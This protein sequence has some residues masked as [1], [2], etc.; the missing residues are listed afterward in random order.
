[1]QRHCC[2]ERYRLAE[3]SQPVNSGV[4]LEGLWLR[5]PV[6]LDLIIITAVALHD[7]YFVSTRAESTFQAET[8]SFRTNARS[9]RSD[10]DLLSDSASNFH[11]AL[12]SQAEST[13][14]EYH[15]AN[16]TDM[17]LH[18]DALGRLK[19]VPNENWASHGWYLDPLDGKLEEIEKVQGPTNLKSKVP[20][21]LQAAA[22]AYEPDDNGDLHIR[23]GQYIAACFVLPVLVSQAQ[24]CDLDHPMSHANVMLCS[25]SH[26]LS[27]ILQ[28]VMVVGTIAWSIE[29]G[30]LW[31]SQR[32]RQRHRAAPKT[33]QRATTLEKSSKFTKL[34]CV[35][36]H[37]SR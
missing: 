19:Q 20:W 3:E 13:G 8:M 7:V 11:P 6:D 18:R 28:F 35:P 29:T 25:S 36:I 22:S 1:M 27:W 5:S 31:M 15:S 9:R 21:V 17:L 37:R 26:R 24:R 14:I 34:S 23:M 12:E 2:E 4:Q 30:T 10:G 16:S 33:L 32:I